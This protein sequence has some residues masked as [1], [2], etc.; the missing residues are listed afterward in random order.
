MV[1]K[2]VYIIYDSLARV[3]VHEVWCV[4]CCWVVTRILLLDNG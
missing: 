3:H 4:A 2:V 1:E